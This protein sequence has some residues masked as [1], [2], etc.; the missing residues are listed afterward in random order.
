MNVLHLPILFIP[1]I[2]SQ[3]KS[4][5]MVDTDYAKYSAKSKQKVVNK[6]VK[7]SRIVQQSVINWVSEVEQERQLLF[8]AI[9]YLHD[10]VQSQSLD[11]S[12]IQ[13][14]TKRLRDFLL[15]KIEHAE[16]ERLHFSAPTVTIDDSDGNDDVNPSDLQIDV[17]LYSGN[18]SAR[19]KNN[20]LTYP[21]D[22]S[23]RG[24]YL[25]L[26]KADEMR[27][28]LEQSESEAAS[29][30][31]KI[32]AERESLKSDRD[33]LLLQLDTV[34]NDL[35]SG[36]ET[37]S[38]LRSVLDETCAISKKAVSDLKIEQERSA[39]KERGLNESYEHAADQIFQLTTELN[40]ASDELS[41]SLKANSNLK[42]RL[43]GVEAV[44]ESER[45]ARDGDKD[46]LKAALK[47]IDVLAEQMN[48]F[49]LKESNNLK[50]SETIATLTKDMKDLELDNVILE[51][52]IRRLRKDLDQANADKGDMQSKIQ[53]LQE[54]ELGLEKAQNKGKSYE[55]DYITLTA[56]LSNLQS[57]LLAATQTA[58]AVELTTNDRILLYQQEIEIFAEKMLT[59]RS[60][61]EQNNAIILKLRGEAKEQMLKYDEMEEKLR[62]SSASTTQEHSVEYSE[63]RSAERSS[64]SFVMS[65]IVR[66][67]HAN[68]TLSDELE[69]CR[70]L[71][72][73]EQTKCAALERKPSVIKSKKIA[74][75]IEA[76]RNTLFLAAAQV[77]SVCIN[78]QEGEQ[79]LFLAESRIK[80]LTAALSLEISSKER[81][82]A[83]KC[84]LQL[85]LNAMKE[86]RSIANI[87]AE[88]SSGMHSS[89]VSDAP[90][91]LFT[92]DNIVLL[93]EELERVTQLKDIAETKVA[94][95]SLV[96]SSTRVLESIQHMSF[97]SLSLPGSPS[98]YNARHGDPG[99]RIVTELEPI[100]ES[101]PN[102]NVYAGFYFPEAD[103]ESGGS[104]SS[105]SSP[106][107]SHSSRLSSSPRG[108]SLSRSQSHS[109]SHS[110]NASPRAVLLLDP[111]AYT[112]SSSTSTSRPRQKPIESPNTVKSSTAVRSL[113][114]DTDSHQECNEDRAEEGRNND[115]YDDFMI[116]SPHQ[117]N[118]FPSPPASKSNVRNSMRNLVGTGTGLE[119]CTKV[120][121]HQ[122]EGGSIKTSPS[123][124]N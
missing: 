1:V 71:L 120:H 107:H 68:R 41:I 75:T 87:M 114:A 2:Y 17:G 91:T 5:L 60:L 80:T 79:R 82:T 70:T 115:S 47:G 31:G 124:K 92:D 26:A 45:V 43:I 122:S 42:N 113:I 106:S 3:R 64:E 35:S 38:K 100:P 6:E 98:L 13:S 40:R 81:E 9:A 109:H 18:R 58:E 123:W 51:E 48:D 94:A 30:I 15:Y 23:E 104:P 39:E 102:L 21:V 85:Q 63:E 20:N 25:M 77:D 61:S 83:L 74:E 19:R 118:E 73:T 27:N 28:D 50:A 110:E 67:L 29:L 88:T 7:Q 99:S 112:R 65:E 117:K 76:S 44:I 78:A 55:E 49:K 101:D 95:L 72:K 22:I 89:G 111:I 108:R 24:V 56:T 54:V 96:D 62:Q 97:E 119:K 14:D 16:E 66:S 33:L 4:P 121:T 84:E 46:T 59:E 52:M 12:K 10:D 32:V 103:S 37:I 34:L 86:S 36:N 8:E 11:I 57:Q 116:S 69:R 105:S 90:C 53:I 93:L